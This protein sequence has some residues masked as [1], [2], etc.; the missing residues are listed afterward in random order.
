LPNH[1]SNELKVSGPRTVVDR[2]M[3]KVAG[4]DKNGVTGL[5]T[6]NAFIPMPADVIRGDLSVEA[7]RAS[8]GR[9]WYSW[10]IQNW[11]TKW[12]VYDVRCDTRPMNLTPL[13]QLVLA[14]EQRDPHT[15]ITYCFN[16]AWGPP[17]EALREMV[18]QH[19]DLKFEFRYA[20]PGCMF[21]GWM[22][23]E[24]GECSEENCSLEEEDGRDLCMEICGFDPWAEGEEEEEDEAE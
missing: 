22:T 14:V 20:E 16:S 1:C 2:F 21:G 7:E 4:P 19:S 9:N 10:S 13:E 5:F 8:N 23:G 15:E 3:H 6:L 17:L 24:D 18:A 11:G 12:D